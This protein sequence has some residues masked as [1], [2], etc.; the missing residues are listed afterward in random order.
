MGSHVI[1]LAGFGGSVVLPSCRQFFE[2]RLEKDDMLN[3]GSLRKPHVRLSIT[4]NSGECPVS[5]NLI[6]SEI[7]SRRCPSKSCYS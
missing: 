2:A 1:S 3:D 5:A 7:K 4:R 6:A